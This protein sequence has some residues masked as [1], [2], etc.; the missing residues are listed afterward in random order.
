VVELTGPE[1][2]VVL[3]KH[4]LRQHPLLLTNKQLQLQ[5]LHLLQLRLPLVQQHIVHLIYRLQIFGILQPN[6]LAS[7]QV[8]N[9]THLRV[10][11][12][13]VKKI[14]EPVNKGHFSNQNVTLLMR[15]QRLNRGRRLER[16]LTLQSAV[17]ECQ[18]LKNF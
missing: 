4:V 16:R 10:E 13:S 15:R 7:L 18:M 2:M 11:L 8:H 5:L 12:T 14:T 17:A 9:S 3:T 6:M 1:Q